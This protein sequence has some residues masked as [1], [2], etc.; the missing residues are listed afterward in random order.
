MSAEGLWTGVE[1]RR[2]SCVCRVCLLPLFGV[3]GGELTVECLTTA[4]SLLGTAFDFSLAL[5]ETKGTFAVDVIL[6][7]FCLFFMVR[8]KDQPHSYLYCH[9]DLQVSLKNTNKNR[10]S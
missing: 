1:V 3:S 6:S 9:L 4:K 5:D 10:L 7:P 8:L 2:A